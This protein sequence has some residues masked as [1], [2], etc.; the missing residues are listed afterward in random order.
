MKKVAWIIGLLIS[1][2]A[3]AQTDETTCL[4]LLEVAEHKEGHAIYDECLYKDKEL[5]WTKWAPLLSQHQY[6]KAMFELS[7]HYPDHEYANLYCKKSA[8]LG[9]IPAMYEQAEQKFRQGKASEAVRLLEKIVKENPWPATKFVVDTQTDKAILK[10][11]TALGI[12]YLTGNG[13]GR[14]INSAIN[15]LSISAKLD[16]P[17]ASN[18]LGIALLERGYPSDKEDGERALWKA[19][20]KGCPAAE[21]NLF[22]LSLLKAQK[23]EEDFAKKELAKRT[24]SCRPPSV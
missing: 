12:S 17:V 4:K 15:F 19:S 23:I 18:A 13:V 3:F 7:Q 11:Y 2:S 5:A 14:Y 21:E 10:A 1:V 6:K 20:L 22:I 16:D 9:Y 24:S 8:D